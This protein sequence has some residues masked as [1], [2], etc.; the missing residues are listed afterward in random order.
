MTWYIQ[1]VALRTIPD[2]TIPL[3]GKKDIIRGVTVKPD[4]DQAVLKHQTRMGK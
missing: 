1:G 4:K 2:V 3:P